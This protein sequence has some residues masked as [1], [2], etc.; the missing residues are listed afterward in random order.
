MTKGES[1]ISKETI[2]SLTLD[3]EGSLLSFDKFIKAQE[4]LAILLHE[5]DKTLANKNRPLINWRIS[6][7]HSGSI[8]LTLEGMPQDQITPSQISEVIKT[9]ERGIV[10]ILEHLIRPK[11]FSDRALESARSLAILKK[12]DEFMVQLGFDSR[13]IDLNQ[14]LIANVDEIIGGKYQ[15]FGTVEGVLKYLSKINYTY[16]TTSC[17]L[18]LA[19]CLS[20]LG[21]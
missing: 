12:R 14:A 16:L 8:H 17:L 1:P 19:S 18:P 5:V 21:N 13:C 20:S 6:Q 10:T 7:I 2:K 15:S 3:I 11:Y 4:Q 9:V